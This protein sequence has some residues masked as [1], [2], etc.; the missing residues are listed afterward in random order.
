MVLPLIHPGYHKTGT[1]WLQHFVF[2]NPRWFRSLYSHADLDSLIVRPHD[3][4]FEAAQ[5]RVEIAARVNETPDGLVPV[6]SSEI[7]CGNPFF[8]SRDSVALMNR[9]R[10]VIPS[11]RIFFTIRRQDDT[12]RSIYVQYVKR[13]GTHTA[14][15]YL[16]RSFEPGYFGFDPTVLEYDRLVIEYARRYGDA[17]VLVLPQELL[18][19]EPSR[20]LNLLLAFAAPEMDEVE[21]SDLHLDKSR[22]GAS[23]GSGALPAMRAVNRLRGGAVNREPMNRLPGLT[24]LMFRIAGKSSWLFPGEDDRI[25]A[26]VR[27]VAAGAFAR[28]NEAVQAYC[29]VELRGFGYELGGS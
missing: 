10:S 15:S 22:L 23:P 28:S 11:A 21:R 16:S 19:T 1:T 12:I 6:I 8:G 4:D 2:S 5:A 3:L 7:L 9:L 24:D 29:P 20:F 13:G 26:Q 18:A 14:S 17:N 27:S 25:A